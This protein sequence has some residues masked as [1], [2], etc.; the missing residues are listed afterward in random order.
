METG[1]SMS[2]D[3]LLLEDQQGGDIL[4]SM[5]APGY[6]FLN[7]GNNHGANYESTTFIFKPG[8]EGWQ[9]AEEMASAL[10]HWVQHTQNLNLH[11]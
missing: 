4:I 2:S 10:L 3:L 8:A 1:V 6:L 7:L 9:Q 11:L 5:N